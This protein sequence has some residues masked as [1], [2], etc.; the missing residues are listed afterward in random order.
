MKVLAQDTVF[1]E[2]LEEY[3]KYEDIIRSFAMKMH[4]RQYEYVRKQQAVSGSK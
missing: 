4:M 2:E 3:V 1:M